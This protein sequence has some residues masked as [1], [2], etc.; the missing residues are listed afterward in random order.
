[1]KKSLLTLILFSICLTG[2]TQE[3]IEV[4]VQMKAQF[5][6][7]QL[8]RQAEYYPTRAE[9][10]TYVVKEL[11]AFTEA[12][13]YDL[14]VT[15]NELEQQGLVSSIQSLWS[16]NALYFTATEEV[17]QTLAERP[18]IAS[19]T[20]VKQYQCIIPEATPK[21][22][23]Q[24]V[25]DYIASSIRQVKADQVWELG[26]MGQGVV[27][28]VVDTGVNYNH[29]DL[30]DHL[31]DGGEEFPN[32][33]YDVYN[34]DDDPMDDNGHGTHCA[35]IVC[36]DG[37]AWL[38]TGA[39]PEA[40]LMCIK[41]ASEEGQCGAVN[42]V[43]G[44]EWAVEHECDLISLSL[45]IAKAELADKELLRHTCEALLDAGIAVIAAAGNEGSATMMN[46]CPIPNNI[47][48]PG[49]CPPPYLDPDQ[50]ENPGGLS[51][52]ICIGAVDEN[53]T[54]AT[55]TSHG[56]V[57]WQDT[58]FADYPFDSINQEIGLIRPDVSAPGVMI[59]S[60]DYNHIN[61]Y[62]YRSGTSQAT[63]CVA[64]IVALMLSQNPLLTPADICQILEETCVKLTPNKSNLTGVGRVDAL[65][66]VNAASLWDAVDES[67]DIVP[68]IHDASVQRIF[69]L[70]GRIVTSDKLSPGI[71]LIQYQTGDQLKTKKILIQ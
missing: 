31:W 17:I 28:A 2:F 47:R 33:G 40:T 34:H 4:M 5:D 12:S 13:Q 18:D 67:F 41:S 65:A 43:K 29:L 26:N 59:W 55:F 58:E 63:P 22:E 45:G 14:M 51:C 64:G 23:H 20:P 6:R 11:K 53:D 49:G 46:I 37:T 56:P 24:V 7:T 57:T 70:T 62:D 71:Y 69:D 60:L 19:I 21:L 16:A 66:A 48:V 44:M 54:T 52:V 25:Y 38:A 27:V 68:D 8:C 39:A 10:R 50:M 42:I 1:M 15:L 35:G 61:D 3:P 9:R 36:G 32:H 30:A